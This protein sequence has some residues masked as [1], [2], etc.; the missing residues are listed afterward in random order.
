MSDNQTPERDD[1][2]TAAGFRLRPD[3]P[4][5]MRLSRKVLAG[6]AGIASLAILGS[7]IWALSTSKR[8]QQSGQELFNTD[9]KTTPDG[10]ASLPKDYTGLPQNVPQLGPPLPGDLGRPILNAHSAGPPAS[11]FETMEQRMAQESEAA[12]TS[13]LFS[14]TSARERPE[15][16]SVLAAATTGGVLNPSVAADPKP[17]IDPDSFQNMQDHKL[18]FLNGPTDRRTVSS[19]RLM[20]SAS[21]Y[22]LQAGTVIPAALITGI[23]SDLPGLITAQVTENVYD[24]PTGRFLLVP[25]GAKLIGSYDSQVSFGQSRVLLVWNRIVFPNGQ[26]IVLEHQPGADTEGYAG[27]E[28]GVDYHWGNLLKT[29]ALSTLLGV[30]AELGSNGNQ[31]DL[32]RALQRGSQDSINQSGQQL[33]RRQINVQPTLTIRPGFPVRVLVNRDLVL[34]QYQ[35]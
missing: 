31:S 27:L 21:S 34:A 17:L 22:V 10:L 1:H 2:E 26:S 25:Q 23:Q 4:K 13:R 35:G 20:N 32:V 28:D 8:G 30:G 29:A 5:V 6:L 33:V 16:G 24:S 9:N 18:A 11:G 12:R 3:R 19:D 15:V 7:L 14:T